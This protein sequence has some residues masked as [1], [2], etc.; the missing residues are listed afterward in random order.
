MCLGRPGRSTDIHMHS[1]CTSVDRAGRPVTVSSEKSE[2]PEPEIGFLVLG[3]GL[4]F[5]N[6]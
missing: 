5:W 1:L 3:L 4:N 2:L 6:L